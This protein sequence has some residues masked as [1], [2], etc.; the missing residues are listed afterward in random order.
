MISRHSLTIRLV[1]PLALAGAACAVAVPA[2]AVT[3]TTTRTATADWPQYGY[4]S[5]LTSGN[6]RETTLS[7]GN[8]H[9]LKLAWSVPDLKIKGKP[10]CCGASQPT[11]AGGV[12]YLGT[13]WGVFAR[14]ATTGKLLWQA[15]LGGGNNTRASKSDARYTVPAVANGIVYA[16]SGTAGPDYGQ[17]T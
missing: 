16:D 15:A 7:A 6:T 1:L 12:V 9:K 3:G 13:S 14:N 17:L 4:G 8:V 10:V 11:V 5:G 2:T